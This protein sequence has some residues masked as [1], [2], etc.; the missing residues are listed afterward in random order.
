MAASSMPASKWAHALLLGQAGRQHKTMVKVRLGETSLH[1][2]FGQC[3]FKSRLRFHGDDVGFRLLNFMTDKCLSFYIV[4]YSTS[5]ILWE[6][7]KYFKNCCIEEFVPCGD[8]LCP[9]S[10]RLL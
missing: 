7:L 8:V 10:V 9:M 4:T 2:V 3:L 6:E 1:Q 5:Y